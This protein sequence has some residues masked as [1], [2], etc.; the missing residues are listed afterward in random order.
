M[1]KPVYA[2]VGEDSFLQLQKLG[3]VRAELPPDV[4]ISEYDGERAELADV[5]DELRSFAMFGGGKLVVVR[6]GDEFITRFR[7][8]LEDY[9][10]K[11]S[12]SG[13][14]VLRVLSL[15]KNQRIYKLIDKHG[16][17]EPCE[18]PKAS[19]LPQWI[20]ARG[21]DPHKLAVE[22]A[23]ASLLADLIGSD[24]GRLD[25]EL[26]KLALQ[27]QG[28][29][30]TTEAVLSSASF[31]REQEIK[32]MTIELAT[33]KPAEALRRWRYLVQLDSSAE[34]RAVTWFTLWLED[35]GA[36]V[37]G[38]TLG[39]NSYRYGDRLSQFTSM[40]RSM[41]RRGHTRAVNMLAE[42]DRRSKSGLGDAVGNI[43]QF[44]LSFAGSA[45]QK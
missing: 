36:V 39:R 33:G 6:N 23:A 8:Q 34:F 10:A 16:A 1:A 15:P 13:T 43:E 30:V 24:L 18:P 3:Q 38:G 20:T 2:L 35:V 31:Q 9:V 32:D 11:P 4:Q 5:L 14:L 44:I 37:R 28:G 7:E 26:A 17:I 40:C 19:Q 41:G 29:R 12:S 45:S 25:N 42:L 22:P 27:V 21:K